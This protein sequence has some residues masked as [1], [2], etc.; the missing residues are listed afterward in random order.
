MV[1][2]TIIFFAN[3]NLFVWKRINSHIQRAL[4]LSMTSHKN[5]IGLVKSTLA[6]AAIVD[7]LSKFKVLHTKLMNTQRLRWQVESL[8]TLYAHCYKEG[9]IFHI[10]NWLEKCVFT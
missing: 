10:D 8:V 2:P 4:K 3:G 9:K 7:V 1:A 5:E 6:I